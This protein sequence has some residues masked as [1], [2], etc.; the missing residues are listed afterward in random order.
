MLSTSVWSICSAPCSVTVGAQTLPMEEP[1]LPNQILSL[2]GQGAWLF[3]G[4]LSTVP[5]M[6]QAGKK[7]QW[8]RV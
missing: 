1:C 3:L 6:S 7:G 8:L 5:C 2:Q 4:A